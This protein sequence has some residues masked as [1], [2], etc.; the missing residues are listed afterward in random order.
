MADTSKAGKFISEIGVPFPGDVVIKGMIREHHPAHNWSRSQAAVRHLFGI[1]GRNIQMTGPGGHG[2]TPFWMAQTGG[3]FLSPAEDIDFVEWRFPHSR[4]DSLDA[5]FDGL[6]AAHKVLSLQNTGSL[7]L[8]YGRMKPYSSKLISVGKAG[9]LAKDGLDAGMQMGEAAAALAAA[10]TVATAGI[11]LGVGAV[12]V[13]AA[14]AIQVANNHRG[15]LRNRQVYVRVSR[16]EPSMR[17]GVYFEYE[18]KIYFN[19][20]LQQ[21]AISLA[22]VAEFVRGRLPGMLVNL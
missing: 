16:S 20:V 4:K 8:T 21:N 19:G 2:T 6:G 5:Q 11:T 17:K 9:S 13:G 22:N 1:K 18:D 15:N 14:I 12:A 10:G 7:Y 3:V